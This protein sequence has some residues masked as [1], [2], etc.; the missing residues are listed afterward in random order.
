MRGKDRDKRQE[1]GYSMRRRDRDEIR[2]RDEWQLGIWVIG[3]DM[4]ERK[5]KR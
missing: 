5:A 2:N 1:C 4:D 3:R